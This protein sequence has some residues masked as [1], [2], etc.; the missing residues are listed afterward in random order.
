V[1]KKHLFLVAALMVFALAAPFLIILQGQ[2]ADKNPSPA[3]DLKSSQRSLDDI[4]KNFPSVEYTSELAAD[5][6]RKSKSAKYDKYKVLNPEIT[7]D[8]NEMSFGHWLPNE[9]PLPVTDSEIIVLGKV[10][11][12]DAHLSSN[13]NAVYSEL[14]IEIEKVF[15]NSKNDEFEE[16]KFVTAERDGGIV[17]FPPGFKMWYLVLGQGM[18]RVGGRYVFFLTHEFAFYG[19]KEKDLFLLTAYE[20]RE[21][22]VYPLDS[23][24]GGTHPVATFYKGKE[25]SVL[26]SDL[27]DA[28]KKSKRLCQSKEGIHALNFI[29]TPN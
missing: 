4:K 6:S 23:P 8:G 25:E 15:K 14:S 22:R 28:L 2:T 12:L 9:S 20:L 19:Y 21:G 26:I 3:P 18:P 7:E 24:D 1:V 16:G 29:D 13:K 11:S 5:E 17:I 27:K 10:T